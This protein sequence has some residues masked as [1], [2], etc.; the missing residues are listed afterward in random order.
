MCWRFRLV[1]HGVN[2]VEACVVIDE[3]QRVLV[4]TVHGSDEGSRDVCMHKSARVG[5]LV[6]MSIVRL[7]SSICLDAGAASV[8]A[9]VGGG[10]RRVGGDG[11]QRSESGGA[12]VE[13]AMHAP[14]IV[15]W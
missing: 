3:I 11:G 2:G 14:R 5:R 8:E 7:T 12:G 1:A 9:P 15:R 10:R 6:M 4:T 13:S